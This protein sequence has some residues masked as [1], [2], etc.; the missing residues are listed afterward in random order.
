MKEQFVLDVNKAVSI[1]NRVTYN[2]TKIMYKTSNQ[3]DLI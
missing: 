1:H 3:I 2:K